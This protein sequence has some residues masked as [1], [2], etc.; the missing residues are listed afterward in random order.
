VA[1]TTNN[2]IASPSLSPE[3]FSAAA[4][5]SAAASSLKIARTSVLSATELPFSQAER[6]VQRRQYWAERDR[7]RPKI[8]PDLCRPSVVLKY[9]AL[10]HQKCAHGV[11]R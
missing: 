11:V 4:A 9:S 6:P 1:S 5:F 2:P 7:P 10:T 3:S 8:T